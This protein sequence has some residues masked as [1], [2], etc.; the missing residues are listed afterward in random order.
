[1]APADAARGT[2]VELR[3]TETF[4]NGAVFPL[5]YAEL[6]RLAR[7]YLSRERPGHTLQATALV[8]E[9]YLRLMPEHQPFAEDRGRFIGIAAHVM[10][11]IL[12]EYARGR[13]RLKRGGEHE[14]VPW[15]DRLA[16]WDADFGRWED[17]D[18]ALDRL[19]ALDARQA[20]VVELRYFGGMTVEEAAEVLDVSAKTVKRDWSIARAWLRRELGA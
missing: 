5:V 15:N 2:L 7:H 18:R 3:P 1:M 17:L 4:S 19:A 14:R 20:K 8:H 11:E 10:R 16:S 9:V 13:N 6:R 12:V